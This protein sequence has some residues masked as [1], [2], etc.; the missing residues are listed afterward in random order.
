MHISLN[1]FFIHKENR[2]VEKLSGGV[3]NCQNFEKMENSLLLPKNKC[4]EAGS[5]ICT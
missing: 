4:K 3:E 1:L 5:N 2:G